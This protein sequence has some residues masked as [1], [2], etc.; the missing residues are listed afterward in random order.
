MVSIPALF[1]C[2]FCGTNMV[3][4][5]ANG[6]A[7]WYTCGSSPT[8]PQ[9]MK[10]NPAPLSGKDIAELVQE[11]IRHEVHPGG[12]NGAPFWNGNARFF[13]YPPAFDFPT[14]PHAVGYRFEVVDANGKMHGFE[15]DRPTASLAPVWADLPTG[16]TSVLCHSV[17]R[18]NGHNV[19]KGTR[20]FWKQAPF[21]GNYPP[22]AR[23]YRECADRA[24]AWL[25]GKDEWKTFM[26]THEA[27]LSGYWGF[28]YPSKM[29]A[30]LIEA[31]LADPSD[32]ERVAGARVCADW[33]IGLS[34]GPDKPLAYFPPTYWRGEEGKVAPAMREGFGGSI[35]REFEGLV[36]LHYPAAFGSALLELYKATKR[37]EY[38]AQARGIADTFVRLQGEDG[39]W[40][41]KMDTR[42]GRETNGNRLI[43]V[44]SAIPFLD[45]MA[46]ATG[47]H[48]YIKAVRRALAYVENGPLKDWNWEAQFE[49]V[50]PDEK[51]RNLTKYD[52]TAMAIF[53]CDRHPDRVAVARELLRFCEDQFICWEHPFP[54]HPPCHD[55]QYVSGWVL[56]GA[57]EQYYWHVPIDASAARLIQTYL[58]LYRVEKNPLDLA[59][60]KA[61]G[62]AIT[63]MQRP[64]G[65]IPTHW[66]GE[67]GCSWWNCLLSDIPALLE[68]DR[69][70]KK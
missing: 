64:D 18:R 4:P 38:L 55:L 14:D 32:A 43:P 28:C 52:A 13:M 59:K 3:H 65:D 39:T 27:G 2:A 29:I 53:L 68:L 30:A 45:A 35:A 40:F 31:L 56:P 23:P 42:T 26:K 34:E 41:L 57:L 50:G 25:F 44:Q 46:T 7:R 20:A 11:D 6:Q 63:R 1:F 37:D 12:V 70:S 9:A 54:D 58:A 21:T 47:E 24:I 69:E 19:L 61:L 49:D 62:D 15:A 66:N 17:D 51:Y 22:A 67:K 48:A 60:A 36:M 33:L 8:L 16:W 10:P 5:L